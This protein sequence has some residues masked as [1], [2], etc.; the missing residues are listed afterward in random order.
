MGEVHKDLV[1]KLP[2][3]VDGF[4]ERN[5]EHLSPA[6]CVVQSDADEKSGFADAMTR[7]NDADVTG[8]KPAMDRVFKQS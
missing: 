7:N 5:M 2:N 8:A 4:I 1:V 6:H 3:M